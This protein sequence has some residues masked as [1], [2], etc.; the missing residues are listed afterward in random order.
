MK[1]VPLR[2]LAP[3]LACLVAAA[4]EAQSATPAADPIS[5]NPLGIPDTR[6]GSGTSWLPDAS[7]MR[8]AHLDAGSWDV[9]VHYSVFLQYD[10]QAGPRGSGQL[11]LVN[12]GMISA[13]R[14]AA[15]GRLVLHG[16]FSAEPW[17]IGPAGYPLLLQTGET[18]DGL[19]IHDRQHP[20]DLFM[21][22]SALY[23][24]AITSGTAFSVYVA[25]V[26]EP[27]VGPV[28]FPHR[29]SAANDPL[30]PI[31]HHWQDATHITF[32]VVTLG[33][34][35][36]AVNVEGSVFNGREPDEDRTDFDNAGRR[37]D[38]WSARVSYNPG[39]RWSLSAW[40]AY[41]ASPDALNP[42]QP[43]RRFG[44]SALTV[45][46]WSD[47]GEWASAVIYGADADV[48]AGAPAPSA[49]L[50]S[51]LD[52][53]G[54]DA[55]FARAEYVRKTAA[56]LAIPSAPAQTGYDVASATVGY[57][58]RLTTWGGLAVGGGVLGLVSFL[59]RSLEALYGS[60]S[61]VGF[62][63]YSTLRPAGGGAMAG[64]TMPMPSRL[65]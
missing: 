6:L 14:D 58:R 22:L 54:R 36:R 42:A 33:I 25:P 53:N 27:A 43:V 7:T 52:L 57:H 24:R 30:A 60:R 12:W 51:N 13:G 17:T 47:R 21:E 49:L 59:P 15:G 4:A 9:M 23:R 62:V 50:E 39:R 19:P 45:E 29:P 40:Y 55:V 38:S 48:A 5:G 32:G 8:A 31:S 64:M 46:P 16:M 3:A 1:L 56:D 44:A 65:P 10:Q 28:A 41:L 35:T 61:P 63:V 34:F 20:H 37:L 11:G 18:H 2:V 26:G